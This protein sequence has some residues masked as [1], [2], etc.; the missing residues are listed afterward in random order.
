[1]CL[2]VFFL[3]LGEIFR[4]NKGKNKVPSTLSAFPPLFFLKVLALTGI[5]IQ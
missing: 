1:M 5:L 4:I 3:I 2:K